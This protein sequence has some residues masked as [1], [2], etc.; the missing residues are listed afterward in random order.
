MSVRHD[1]PV[2][3]IHELR[4]VLAAGNVAVLTGAG[5]STE[6]GIPD[7]RGPSGA[8]HRTHAPMTYQ[9]FTGDPSARRRYWARGFLGWHHIS[10]AQPNA[11]HRAVADLQRAGLVDGLITQNVDGLHQRAGSEHCIDLHGRLD[12]VMCMNCGG[13]ESRDS[14]HRRLAAANAGWQ[15]IVTAFNPDGDVDIPEERLD[16]FVV[17]SCEVCE[18][19]LKPDVVYF[20]EDVP[21]T[22]VRESYEIVDAAD[23]LFV[24]GSSLHVFSGRRF[25]MH[26]AKAGKNV[27]IVNQGPTKADPLATLR[28]EAPLGAVLSA[29]A[30]DLVN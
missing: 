24:L 5:I 30:L 23:T 12:R 20:G 8:S 26:A 16:E 6:S 2:A 7:Y 1:D 28:L 22:R 19:A 10:R 13:M 9:V 15:A 11:G 25:V 17:V 4:A 29:L 21:K 27:V 3:K 14:V 18:G